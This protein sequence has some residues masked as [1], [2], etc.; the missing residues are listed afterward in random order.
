MEEQLK[1]KEGWT[2]LGKWTPEQQQVFKNQ[3]YKELKQYLKTC[4]I[5]R[6]I[7]GRKNNDTQ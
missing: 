6:K 2:H 4:N 7:I 1:V 3:Q 5:G